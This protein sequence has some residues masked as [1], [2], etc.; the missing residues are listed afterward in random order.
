MVKKRKPVLFIDDGEESNDAIQ[1]F[2]NAKIAYVTYHI[3]KF[4]KD[5]C[6]D[7]PTTITPSVFAPDGVF[8]GFEGV[9][10]YVLFRNSDLYNDESPS[11]YW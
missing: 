6:G 7:V 8:R 9:K 11:A 2:E 10:D 1:L 5:C 3:K 4:E